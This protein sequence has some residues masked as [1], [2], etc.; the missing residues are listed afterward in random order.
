MQLAAPEAPQWA[1]AVILTAKENVNR[2]IPV[3]EEPGGLQISLADGPLYSYTY[4]GNRLV[5]R[6]A[7]GSSTDQWVQVYLPVRPNG[8]RAWVEAKYFNRSVVRHHVLVDLSDRLVALFEGDELITYTRA[9]VGKPSTP[10]PARTGY[11]VEKL[12][13]HS[14]QN[15]GAA[16]GDWIL[17]LSFFS[18]TLD[19]FAGGLPRVALHGTNV[20]WRV[21]QAISNGCIRLPNEAI[22]TIARNAPLGTVVRVRA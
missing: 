19:S 18:D 10:T 6:V 4:R 15:G 20:P 8:T 12:P 2:T 16:Y 14:R 9:I 11:I 7:E 13:N 3:Y 5:L 1:P 22:N 21:G 17:M